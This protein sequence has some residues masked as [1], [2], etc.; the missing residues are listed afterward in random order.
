MVVVYYLAGSKKQAKA[1]AARLALN[2]VCGIICPDPQA[3]KQMNPN[4][5][6]N[7]ANYQQNK[8]V[9]FFDYT[10]LGLRH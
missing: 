6:F 5:D 4:I 7:Q 10:L 3:V 2:K 8:W 9:Q 1:A